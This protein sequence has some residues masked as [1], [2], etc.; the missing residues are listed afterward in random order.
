MHGRLVGGDEAPTPSRPPTTCPNRLLHHRQLDG[1]RHGQRRGHAGAVDRRACSPPTAAAEPAASSQA[2]ARAATP[3]HVRP[4]RHRRQLLHQ[5]HRAA[6]VGSSESPCPGR[7]GGA[8]CR[9]ATILCAP[10]CRPTPKASGIAN[11]DRGRHRG[12]RRAGRRPPD[13]PRQLVKTA[14]FGSD[15]NWGRVL[16]PPSRMA[17]ITLDPSQISVS[18]NGAA[19]CA[20]CGAPGCL[21]RVDTI[22]TRTSITVDLGVGDRQARIEPLICRMPPS[23][24]NSA[25]AHE[26]HRSC[27]PTSKRECWP[28]AALAQAV[29]RQGRRRQIRRQRD[30]RRRCSARSPPT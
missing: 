15:P 4:A 25:Y 23:K 27:H 21:A 29:A 1:R 18:F 6:V 8:C 28:R 20:R 16:A 13:R 26:P 5:R 11:R 14:L 12:G 17:P 19:V 22:R 7:S 10:S 30:D 2:C 9:S 24:R 3:N